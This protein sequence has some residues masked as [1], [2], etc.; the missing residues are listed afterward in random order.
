MPQYVSFKSYLNIFAIERQYTYILDP[1]NQKKYF[2]KQKTIAIL[3][4]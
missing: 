3:M 4:L 2:T 1:Q